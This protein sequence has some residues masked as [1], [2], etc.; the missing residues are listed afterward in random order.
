MSPI[1]RRAALLAG[2]A[3]LA[4]CAGTPTTGE[5]GWIGGRFADVSREMRNWEPGLPRI[6]RDGTVV[7]MPQ[8]AAGDSAALVTDVFSGAPLARAG[9][10]PGDLVLSLDGRPVDGALDLRERCEALKPGTAADVAYWRDGATRNARIV[11]GRET[12]QSAGQI[13]FGLSL[14]PT[15]DLW[16]FDDG[17]DVFGLL[18]VHWDHERHDIVGPEAAYLRALVPDESVEGPR[19]ESTDVWFLLGGVS[20]GKRVFRQETLP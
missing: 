9:L 7:G 6:E 10:A 20:K 13:G 5:R 3:L 18:R 12:F 16:P 15:L 11:V 2:A 4:A 8:D 19:Q 1:V 17:I 14:S